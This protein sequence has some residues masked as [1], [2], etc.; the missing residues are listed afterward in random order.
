ML[1]AQEGHMGVVQALA[2]CG[3]AEKNAVM[4][5]EKWSALH[6][7]A[8][9]GHEDVVQWMIEKGGADSTLRDNAGHVALYYCQRPQQE[10]EHAGSHWKEKEKERNKSKKKKDSLAVENLLANV[11]ASDVFEYMGGKIE[12]RTLAML[13]PHVERALVHFSE[14]YERAAVKD[15]K[16]DEWEVELG[17]DPVK[18]SDD[19]FETFNSGVHPVDYIASYMLR[20]KDAR[21]DADA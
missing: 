1:A 16:K 7:A 11:S 2:C 8:L 5:S 18:R 3:T 14:K 19:K 6:C 17:D 20:H 13:L 4:P 21:T 9:G 10:E 12:N 15:F